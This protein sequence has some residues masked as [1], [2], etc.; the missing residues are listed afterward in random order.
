MRILFIIFFYSIFVV[1]KPKRIIIP[2]PK[3]IKETY[4]YERTFI[5]YK[6]G[7][8]NKKPDE[9]HLKIDPLV[10]EL[11]VKNL[12]SLNQFIGIK[13]SWI[14]NG[15]IYEA[16]QENNPLYPFTNVCTSCGHKD[17]MFRDMFCHVMQNHCKKNR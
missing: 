5:D 11:N 12:A 6:G 3:G 15:L 8:T 10:L 16:P 9:P 2:E 7:Y 14:L 13:I 17:N 4:G 1:S